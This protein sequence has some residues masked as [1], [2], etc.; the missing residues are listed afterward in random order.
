M[1]DRLFVDHGKCIVLLFLLGLTSFTSTCIL[2]QSET[3][4]SK[5]NVSPQAYIKSQAVFSIF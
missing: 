2:K 1:S 3:C 4:L 5:C